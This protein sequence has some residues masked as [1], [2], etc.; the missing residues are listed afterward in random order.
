MT[1]GVDDEDEN[2]CGGCSEIRE[3]GGGALFNDGGTVTLTDVAFTGRSRRGRAWSRD[4]EQRDPQHERRHVHWRRPS[5]PVHHGGTITG[6]EVTF[7]DDADGCCDYD[8]GAAYLDGGTVTLT[9]T[10]VVGSGGSASIGGGIDNAAATLTLTNDTLSGN[11]RGSLQTDPGGTTYVENTIIGAGNSDGGDGDCV[12]S[13][14]PDDING[15]NSSTAIT[16]DLGDNIDQDGSCDL[17]G[18]TDFPS[19]D[20]DLAP[21]FD[22]GGGVADGGT[23]RPAARPSAIPP[24]RAARRR[25]AAGPPRPIRPLRHRRV[26]GRASTPRSAHRVRRSDRRASPTPPLCLTSTINLDGEAGGFHFVYGT[27]PGELTQ[28]TPEAAAG[29]VSMT[30]S[31]VRDRN[32]S[33]PRHHLLLRRDSRQCDRFHPREQRRAVHDPGRRA[34]HL[35][36]QRR[37]GHRH[38][39]DDRLHG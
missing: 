4:R 33:Q 30:R 5:D 39:R 22:N 34:E 1:G 11:T 29:V 2:L 6:N 19:Q 10:T 13:G 38:D 3:N 21:I 23:V 7:Q 36:R 35:E 17:T 32:R 9:N 20:P 8:G 25:M 26:R 12:A 15:E 18:A 27:S 28:S 16:H 31:G 37:L 24:P 14:R